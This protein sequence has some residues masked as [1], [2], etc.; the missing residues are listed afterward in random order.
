[1]NEEQIREYKELKAKAE[2]TKAKRQ[3]SYQARALSRSTYK[4]FFLK[5]ASAQEKKSL[6]NKIAAL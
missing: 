1:M 3:E 5:N 6:E 2:M 4:E